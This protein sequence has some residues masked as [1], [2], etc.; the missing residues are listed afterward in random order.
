MELTSSMRAVTNVVLKKYEE[1]GQKEFGEQMKDDLWLLVETLLFLEPDLRVYLTPEVQRAIEGRSFIRRKGVKLL[2]INPPHRKHRF[3]GNK[4][5][6]YIRSFAR[7]LIKQVP[8]KT[9]RDRLELVIN[10][11]GVSIIYANDIQIL[12]LSEGVYES[13][14]EEYKDLSFVAHFKTMHNI[15]SAER[16]L[17]DEFLDNKVTERIGGREN[18]IRVKYMT[19]DEMLALFSRMEFMDRIC[20]Q[21]SYTRDS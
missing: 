9:L 4:D 3:R 8:S 17:G 19:D 12:R 2:T 5:R 1:I 16:F 10:R 15:D 21:G 11:T 20:L 14:V 13:S 6:L 18:S 7:K